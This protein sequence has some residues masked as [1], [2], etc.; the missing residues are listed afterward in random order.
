M[1]YLHGLLYHFSSFLFSCPSVDSWQSVMYVTMSLTFPGHFKAEFLMLFCAG[2][3]LWMALTLPVHKCD[4][5]SL[6]DGQKSYSFL[7]TVITSQKISWTLDFVFVQPIQVFFIDYLIPSSKHLITFQTVNIWGF[8]PLTLWFTLWA[9]FQMFPYI[10]AF[11]I[12][13]MLQL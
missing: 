12:Y 11:I 9:E 10:K 6:N 7:F 4:G 13:L 2:S 5:Q 8:F 1:Y 3:T